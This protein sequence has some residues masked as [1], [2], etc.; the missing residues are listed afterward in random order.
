MSCINLINF[1][2]MKIGSLSLL[3]FCNLLNFMY[4]I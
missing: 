2:K 1:A 3:E 4:E